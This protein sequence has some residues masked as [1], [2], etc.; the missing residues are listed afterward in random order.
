MVETVY[1]EEDIE[2]ILEIAQATVYNTAS[3]RRQIAKLLQGYEEVKPASQIRKE[4]ASIKGNLAHEIV[5]M[6]KAK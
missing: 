5:K 6:R 1:R 4:L 3:M 2:D